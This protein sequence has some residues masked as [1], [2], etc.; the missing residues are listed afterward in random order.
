MSNNSFLTGFLKIS[1]FE[2]L[3][4]LA[5]LLVA[6]GVLM[7]LK[8]KMSF[9]SRM[10]VGLV[11][12]LAIGLFAE[13]VFS[14]STAYVEVARTEINLWY[15]LLGSTFVRLIQLMSVPVVFLAIF[16]VI[17]DFEGSN[18]KKFS[19]KSLLMLLGTT[20]I[21]AVVG[22]LAAHLFNLTDS[23]LTAQIADSKAEQIST[24]SAQSFP[25]FAL[26]L[27]PNNIVGTM[28]TNS[29]IISLVIISVLF[30]TAAKFLLTKDK[31]NV[32]KVVTLLRGLKE[33]VNSVLINI[34][35]L[36]PY[37]VIALVAKSIISN[38]LESILG[39]A[40]FIGAIYTAVVIQM[41]V[42]V[43][44]LVVTGLNPITFYKKAFS[45]LV[46]AFSSR[47]SV[48]TLPYTIETLEKDMGVSSKTSNFIATLGTTI[49]MNGCAGIFPAILAVLVGAASGVTLNLAF[50]VLVVVVV[51]LGSIGIAGVPGTSTVAATVT[52]NGLGLGQ[53]F[54]SIGAVFG[55]DPIV[56]MG[57]T[58]LNVCGSMVSSVVVD[59]W[60]GTLDIEQFNK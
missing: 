36:M 53:Y 12:G 9:S 57:R 28:A 13:L 3:I 49:G 2:T 17:L 32:A 8:K 15:S 18:L 38:G 33:L 46:F 55:V 60:E 6:V 44:I 40:G 37:A 45:T 27:V 1:T 7:F 34:I 56:D 4:I 41:L 47:S 14:S 25:E 10:L 21:A 5:I 30:A 39:L 16:F 35:K 54:D 43:V 59:K 29:G 50:Y 51:T 19:A 52:L 24:L 48:G 11:F 20:A 31:E 23:N 26:N 58:M 22:I 42:Y